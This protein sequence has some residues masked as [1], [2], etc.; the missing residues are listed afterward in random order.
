M[1]VTEQSV[2]SVR[3]PL[4]D[5]TLLF[6]KTDLLFPCVRAVV[7]RGEEFQVSGANVTRRA[8]VGGGIAAALAA[9]GLAGCG[10]GGGRA[11]AA[12]ASDVDATHQ[13]TIAMS[14]ENEPDAGFDPCVDWGC[15]EHVHEP[16]IQS[17]LIVTDEDMNFTNDLATDWSCS[18][19]KLT[20]TFKI[21]DDVTFSD[22][23]ALTAAD[24]AFTINTI[25][26][27]KNAQADL[28]MVADATAPDDTT[29]LITL[30]KPCNTL[31]YTLANMGIVPE[32]AYGPDYG[33]NPIGSGRYKLVQWD[34]GQQ[35]ILEAN[36]SYYG[37]KPNIERV[38]VVFMAEDAALAAARAGQVDMAYTSATLAD[39]TI[40]G[41]S[42]EAYD[43]VDS[44]GIQ[45]PVIPT[46][47]ERADGDVTYPAGNDVTCNVEVRRAINLGVDRQA[48]V[49][50]VLGGYGKVAYSIGDGMPWASDGM[51]CDYDP[52]AA[53]AQLEGAGWA[54]GEDGVYTREG[55]RC[56]LDL[57]YPASDSVRQSM[58]NAFANQ[59]AQIGI[60]VNTHG[61]SWDDL[62]PHEFSDPIT[63]GWGSN[64]PSD[65]Y[66]LSHSSGTMNYSCY[67]DATVDAYLDEAL[68]ADDVEASYPLWQQSEWDGVGGIAPAGD[69]TW[70]WLANVSHLYWK[71]DGLTVARQK[72]QPHGHGWS[73]LN[74][75]DRWSWQ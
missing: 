13:V 39:Q 45:L 5:S 74:N 7:A 47:S 75:V 48:I 50:G 32:H 17:T 41:Y 57:Y 21:R 8:F 58:A 59:M 68:A 56:S 65:V 34:R 71:R 9:C 66:E 35:A 67:S 40:E 14:A 25:C 20:W 18:P 49:D 46:G 1:L 70:V 36:P 38:V 42:L 12:T 54:L 61:G 51:R 52:Q 31:L 37:E 19:D 4:N 29:A 15:G 16:L 60:E 10:N 3:I 55:L 2:Q 24:V 53:K 30:S 11:G 27:S 22:G 43:T 26:G 23:Q 63:W 44:R 6:D 69:A 72:L 33:A 64:S 62:Y 73:V 28:S